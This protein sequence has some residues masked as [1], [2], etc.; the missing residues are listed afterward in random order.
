MPD[1]I[2]LGSSQGNRKAGRPPQQEGDGKVRPDVTGDDDRHQREA[3]HQ[4]DQRKGGK[5]RVIAGSPPGR[6]RVDECQGVAKR[7][8]GA[9]QHPDFGKHVEKGA[10]TSALHLS[11]TVNRTAQAGAPGVLDDVLQVECQ[12]GAVL[13]EGG[14]VLRENAETAG[15]V[16]DRLELSDGQ[17]SLAVQVVPDE[18]RRLAGDVV[19]G[20]VVGGGV[21]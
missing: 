16:L 2:R 5:E 6:K 4:R 17:R 18:L 10:L 14:V 20:A 13:I 8:G 9:T 21:G 19:P 1:L 7:D 11:E 15:A 3:A 12:R